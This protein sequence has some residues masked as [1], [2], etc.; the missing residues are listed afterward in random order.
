MV[1]PRVEQ[2]NLLAVGV[3]TLSS[4]F[5]TTAPYNPICCLLFHIRAIMIWIFIL[6]DHIYMCVVHSFRFLITNKFIIQQRQRPYT[7]SRFVS[8]FGR[9]SSFNIGLL[10]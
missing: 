8:L 9:T 1:E 4:I 5:G 10:C 3:G 6:Y 2:A 7:A